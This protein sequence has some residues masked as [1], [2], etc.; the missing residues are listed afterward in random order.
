MKVTLK[1]PIRI[2]KLRFGKGENDIPAEL[3]DHWFVQA[4]LKSGDMI[5]EEAHK[6]AAKV[7]KVKGSKPAPQPQA[8]SAS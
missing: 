4:L 7:A 6:V 2:G 1:C 3:H 5:A 8:K